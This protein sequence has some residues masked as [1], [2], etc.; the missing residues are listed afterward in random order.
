MYHKPVSTW[1]QEIEEKLLNWVEICETLDM[2]GSERCKRYYF[3]RVNG[4]N[5]IE[6]TR[7]PCVSPDFSLE[8]AFIIPV[9]VRLRAKMRRNDLINLEYIP[10]SR[11]R[12]RV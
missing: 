10:V 11:F 6:R 9:S 2:D 3:P 4:G 5:D 1:R 12:I 8:R 7:N